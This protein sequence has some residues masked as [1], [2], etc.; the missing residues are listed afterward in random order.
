VVELAEAEVAM[1][2]SAGSLDDV[3]SRAS[4]SKRRCDVMLLSLG[5]R[6]ASVSRYRGGAARGRVLTADEP[7]EHVAELPGGGVR[8]HALARDC[9][10]TATTPFTT[11]LC[12]Q[13]RLRG[14]LPT[15][16]SL[17]RKCVSVDWN[18]LRDQ[19]MVANTPHVG[20]GRR[21]IILHRQPVDE[22]TLRR[23]G[24]LTDIAKAARS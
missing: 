9:T 2:A 20:D 15:G 19:G 6:P 1:G 23:P 10:Q 17:R 3:S 16:Q 14:L 21:R 8:N 5:R 13:P 7:P 18:G 24:A 11:W 12:P 4:S 22:L